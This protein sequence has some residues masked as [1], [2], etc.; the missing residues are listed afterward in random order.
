MYKYNEF[1]VSFT[2]QKSSCK[3][4]YKIPFF[5]IVNVLVKDIGAQHITLATPIKLAS[6]FPHY[7]LPWII[8]YPHQKT[9]MLWYWSLTQN[10]K[11]NLFGAS[12]T[13][14]ISC[15]NLDNWY[16]IL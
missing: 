6:A 11:T 9:Y 5:L 12:W 10:N 15:W 7:N 14:L 13:Y 8:Y 4:N 3:A 2:T 1:E 16:A